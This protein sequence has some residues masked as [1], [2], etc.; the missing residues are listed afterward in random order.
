MVE[1]WQ[2][3]YHHYQTI[4]YLICTEATNF[5]LTINS[6]FPKYFIIGKLVKE[7]ER[8]VTRHLNHW[9]RKINV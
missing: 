9:F 1:G 4:I 3:I 2:F 7:R 5:G 6:K 8:G